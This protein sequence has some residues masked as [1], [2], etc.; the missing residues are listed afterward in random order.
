MLLVNK[1]I[2]TFPVL[3]TATATVL[4]L[5]PVQIA[6]AK[7]YAKAGFIHAKDGTHH[8][9]HH[10]YNKH[11]K[12][13]NANKHY[14][15]KHHNSGHH[16]TKHHNSKHNKHNTKHHSIRHH[17]AGHPNTRYHGTRQYNANHHIN[18]HHNDHQGYGVL[19]FGIANSY[20]Y[21]NHN[22]HQS[23]GY[24]NGS[25]NYT[26]GN[27]CRPT[28]KYQSDSY[29]NTTRINGTLCYDSYGKA[30]IVPGSRY[31]AGRYR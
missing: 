2:V 30:Y 31:V 17:N 26:G 24:N 19:S 3:V 16:G 21:S 10:A 4:A 20:P 14:G 15:T 23:Y 11:R 12:H 5:M 27:N 8:R 9:K 29:G 28:H 1:K 22:Q 6:S 13:A 7:D 25:S 18:S